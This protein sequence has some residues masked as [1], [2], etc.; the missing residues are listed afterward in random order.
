MRVA[1][2][3]M[4]KNEEILLSNV[5][6]IWKSYPVDYF[7]F[8]DDNSSDNTLSVIQNILPK[9]NEVKFGNTLTTHPD[10]RT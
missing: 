5:L 1:I 2:N 7:I 4:V 6:P 9:E 10:T 3:T 8:Y